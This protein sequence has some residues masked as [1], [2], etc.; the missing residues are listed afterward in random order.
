M[1][2]MLNAFSNEYS[3]ASV[4]PNPKLG[5]AIGKLVEEL[6]EAGVLLAMAGLAA[7]S[8]GARIQLSEGKVNVTDGPFTE[9]KEVIGGAWIVE[10]D[11]KTDAIEIGKRIWRIFAEVYGPSYAGEGE[12]RELSAWVNFEAPDRG[13]SQGRAG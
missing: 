2:F 3:E 9:T 8:K 4:P 12:V 5:P 13:G 1:Q 11:S 7:T 6:S 10:V